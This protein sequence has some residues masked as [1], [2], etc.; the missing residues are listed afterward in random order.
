MN[1]AFV[2]LKNKNNAPSPNLGLIST[3]MSLN[4]FSHNCCEI[5]MGTDAKSTCADFGKPFDVL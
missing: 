1:C 2:N 5:N 3:W 4:R